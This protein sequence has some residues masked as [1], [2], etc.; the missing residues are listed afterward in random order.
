MRILI[1]EDDAVLLGIIVK[2]LMA[3]GYAVDSCVNGLD[4][5]QYALSAD[6]DAIILDVMLPGMSG[7]NI[8][9]S[10][11]KNGQDVS[12]LLLTARDSIQDRVTG[13]DF[14]ADD[15]LTKPFAFD[16][17]LARL[18][19]LLRRKPTEHSTVLKLLDLKMDTAKHEV[20]R[21]EEKIELT[22][23]E[24]ALLEYLLRNA[25]NVMTRTQII[26]HVWNY[27][28]DIE[29]NLVDVYIRYLRNKIDKDSPVKLLHTVRGYG[30]V[31]KAGEA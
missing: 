24:Y 5:L 23:K 10:L 14:G 11:R 19:V 15:Y 4:G 7:L 31:L 1:V 22:M 18:R 9:K 13:L 28:S 2:R 3:N 8:L 21:A 27:D 26:D 30:Y 12:V 25:G 16:E 29:S 20:T 6:Y 17:L